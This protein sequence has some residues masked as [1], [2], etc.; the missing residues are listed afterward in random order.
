M[1]AFKSK[2]ELRQILDRVLKELDADPEQGAKLRAAGLQQR[3]E[4]TDLGLILNVGPGDEGSD[5]LRWKFSD[6]VDWKPLVS[7]KMNSDVANA[8]LQGKENLA[9][10]IVRK[11]IS[12]SC[13][14]RA[15]VRYLP[16]SR[17]IFE[18]YRAIVESDYPHLAN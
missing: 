10:A 3:I 5:H 14:A 18:R 2:R 16:A 13:D 15:V 6:R 9:I 7:L 11:R 1:S 12:T 8:Y 4:V 17:P